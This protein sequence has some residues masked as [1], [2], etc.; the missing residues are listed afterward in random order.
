MNITQEYLK[1]IL[2]YEPNSGVFTWLIRRDMD[3]RWNSRWA[4]KTAGWLKMPQGYLQIGINNKKYYSHRLAWLYMTG[5]FPSEID[6]ID[7]NKSN[8]VYSNIREA[9]FV[10]NQRNK[11]I[12]KNNVSGYKGVFFCN[13][14][15]K[16]VA[17]IRIDIKKDI[18]LGSFGCPTAAHFAYCRAAKQYHGEFARTV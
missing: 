2:H 9:S 13:Q 3:N 10:Q 7:G 15:K 6:H 8:N 18:H 14:K 4:G 11:G 5:Q 17:K 12:M 1:S 16:W